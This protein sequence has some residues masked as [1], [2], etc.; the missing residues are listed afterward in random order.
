MRLIDADALK[1]TNT[2]ALIN[3]KN[4]KYSI[5]FAP[6]CCVLMEDVNNAP[7]IENRPKGEWHI[8][9]SGVRWCKFCGASESSVWKNFCHNCGAIMRGDNK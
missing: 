4:D 2:Y 7:T 5:S 8:D 6:M 1:K 9:E 3:E